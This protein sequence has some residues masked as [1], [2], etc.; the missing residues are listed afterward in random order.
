M[1]PVRLVLVVMVLGLLAACAPTLQQAGHPEAG[2]SGPRLDDADFVSFDGA[3]LGLTRWDAQDSHGERV[4]PWAVVIGVH[5]M[6]DYANAFHMAAP[7]WAEQG[8][9]T[10]AYDQRGFGRSPR[11]GVW[12]PDALTTED[13]RTIV[14]LARRRWPHAVIA[15]AG[16]SL[17]GAVAIEAF[18]SDR[19]PA[20]DRLVLLSPAV[21]GWSSQPFTYRALLWMAARAA[22]GKVFTPPDWLTEHIS[23]SDNRAELI[24]M[25]ADPLMIWGARSDALYGLVTTMQKASDKV[26]GLHAP[27]LYLYGAHDEIIPRGAAVRAVKRLPPTA[28]TAYYRD[29]WHLLMRD[30]EGPV[31][32]RDILSFIRDPSEAL[33]SGAPPIL[34]ASTLKRASAEQPSAP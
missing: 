9:T 26:G 34:G 24:A 7:W 8:V 17:G 22:P 2:F 4:E 30:E 28:R 13:L 6:N 16:E 14:A 23:P 3:R 5:G 10:L 19:P 18:A 25:G 32:W 21:W 20:A 31:V 15:V 11:R 33:P 27:T 12:A 29:G 1:T